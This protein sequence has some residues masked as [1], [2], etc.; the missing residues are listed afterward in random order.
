MKSA[1]TARSAEATTTA[2]HALTPDRERAPHRRHHLRGRDR[3]RGPRGRRVDRARRVER[4]R[5]GGGSST[6]SS[7]SSSSIAPHRRSSCA[8]SSPAAAGS[9][10]PEGQGASRRRIASRPRRSKV[11]NVS[12]P[13]GGGH[14]RRRDVPSGRKSR[15]RPHRGGEVEIEDVGAVEYSAGRG[16]L[17]VAGVKGDTSIR[18]EQGGEVTRPGSRGRSTSK[19]AMRRA[20]DDLSSTNTTGPGCRQRR[21]VMDGASNRIRGSTAATRSRRDDG[22]ARAG[23]DL[24]RR[25]ARPL[26]PPPGGYTLDAASRRADCAR[27]FHRDHGLPRT[28][29]ATV[30]NEVASQ[31]RRTNHRLRRYADFTIR[32]PDDKQKTTS[33]RQTGNSPLARI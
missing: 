15:D 9:A 33:P 23:G 11:T 31:G 32:T 3:R 24:Q 16:T 30:N 28:S 21:L 25:R 2:N 8:W 18:M 29:P 1:A 19:D 6:S 17:K 13:G 27:R 7:R 20:L 12:R 14:A 4:L 5:R 22:R 26:T 10:A